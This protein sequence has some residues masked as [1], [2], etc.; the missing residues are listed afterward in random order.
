MLLC[1]PHERDQKARSRVLPRICSQTM[2]K[3]RSAETLPFQCE[4]A[5]AATVALLSPY[6]YLQ[7]SEFPCEPDQAMC[8]SSF[9][10]KEKLVWLSGRP[11]CTGDPC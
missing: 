8:E 9:S 5:R 2:Q 4:S 3:V 11:E 1:G 10:P 6:H 7:Q